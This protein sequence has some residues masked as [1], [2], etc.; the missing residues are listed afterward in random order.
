VISP[1]QVRKLSAN[2]RILQRF[3]QQASWLVEMKCIDC[4]NGQ[5]NLVLQQWTEKRRTVNLRRQ[6]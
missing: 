3:L 1:I 4:A 5:M 2:V 6:E